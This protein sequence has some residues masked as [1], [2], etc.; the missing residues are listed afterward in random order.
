MG[1]AVSLG[2]RVNPDKTVRGL[3]VDEKEVQTVKQIFAM[4]L[5]LA[6]LR[7]AEASLA[8]HGILSRPRGDWLAKPFSLG[9]IHKILTNP[10][11][12]GKSAT[13]I[14][15]MTAGMTRSSIGRHGRAFNPS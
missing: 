2:Y 1:G 11:Y 8:E 14:R 4:Y 3:L 10:I 13:R 6:C 12:A 15:L 5:E 7:Q 9:A